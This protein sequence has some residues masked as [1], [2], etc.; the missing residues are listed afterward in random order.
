MPLFGEVDFELCCVLRRYCSQVPVVTQLLQRLPDE[1]YPQVVL[2]DGSGILHHRGFG[3][4]CHLGVAVDIP[5]I[6]VAKNPLAIDGLDVERI[7]AL[8]RAPVAPGQPAGGMSGW[9]WAPGR[10]AARLQGDSGKVS[11]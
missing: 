2:V 5:T 10:L 8:I 4:A 9:D 11:S 1:Y 6:G 7:R 3:S